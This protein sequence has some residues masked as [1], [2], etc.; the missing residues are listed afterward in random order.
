[1]RSRQRKNLAAR[2]ADIVAMSA[3]TGRNTEDFLRRLDEL[4][5]ADRGVVKLRVPQGDGAAISWLYRNADVLSRDDGDEHAEL[6]VSISPDTL[7]R[8]E[9]KPSR[10]LVFL[11]RIG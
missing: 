2:E 8:F 11:Y 6:E 3:V 9:K 10:R 4:L 7:A 5:S 1:M